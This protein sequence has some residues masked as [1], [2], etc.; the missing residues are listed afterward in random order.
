MHA[1]D[2]E[3]RVS[4]LELFYDL[5]FVVVISRLAHHLSLHPDAGGVLEFALP[6]LPLVMSVAALGATLTNA[7][8]FV[9]LIGRSRPNRR[10]AGPPWPPPPFP[11]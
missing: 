2:E 11:A 8:T 6:Y 1:G 10:Y 7:G 4:F 5:V 3:R 9:T